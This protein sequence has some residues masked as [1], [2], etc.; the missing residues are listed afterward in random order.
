MSCSSNEI[1][2]SKEKYD[3][4]LASLHDKLENCSDD[5]VL[6]DVLENI[7]TPEER[8]FAS[9]IMNKYTFVLTE[10]GNK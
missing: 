4:L 5:A 2:M 6:E 8:L 1:A 3:R 7:L 10:G 9:L